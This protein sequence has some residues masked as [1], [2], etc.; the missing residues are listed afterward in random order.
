MG[1]TARQT[2]AAPQGQRDSC[3]EIGVGA[4]SRGGPRVPGSIPLGGAMLRGAGMAVGI[5]GT[6]V[7][8]YHCF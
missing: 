7:K 4:V 1:L 8:E 3:L 5:K 6:P 2:E